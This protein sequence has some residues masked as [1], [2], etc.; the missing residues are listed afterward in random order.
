M[1]LAKPFFL[2]LKRESDKSWGESL[3]EDNFVGGGKVIL[4]PPRH[5]GSDS[6]QAGGHHVARHGEEAGGEAGLGEE[7]KLDLFVCKLIFV[8]FLGGRT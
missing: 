6:G 5:L 4:L 7:A 3:R 2:H 8:L 1:N